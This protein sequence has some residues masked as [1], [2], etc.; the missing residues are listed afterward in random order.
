VALPAVSVLHVRYDAWASGALG[1]GGW[2]GRAGVFDSRTAPGWAL[3]VAARWTTT[4]GAPSPGDLPGWTAPGTPLVEHLRE[5]GVD[6]SLAIPFAGRQGALALTGTWE[7]RSGAFAEEA[8]WIDAGASLA[9]RL[10]GGGEDPREGAFV[11]A[12]ARKLRGGPEGGEREVLAGAGWRGAV[13]SVALDASVPAWAAAGEAL[14]FSRAQARLG[15]EL[16][17]AAR[18]RGGVAWEGE[19]VLGGGVGFAGGN[20]GLDAGARY[21]LEE[22]TTVWTLDVRLA[23]PDI[24]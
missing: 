2:G 4:E 17:G 7:D 8:S 20:W 18:L 19:P 15:G 12:G 10:V 21:R 13:G 3:G 23:V 22:R 1:G 6:G 5:R 16:G 14:A 11:A 24:E 9:W